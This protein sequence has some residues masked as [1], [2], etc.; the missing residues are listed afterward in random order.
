MLPVLPAQAN[1][2]AVKEA[3]GAWKVELLTVQGP[4]Q[5]LL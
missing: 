5:T 2:W 1:T 3:G 4:I